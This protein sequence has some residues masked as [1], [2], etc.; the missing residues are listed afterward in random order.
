M[1]CVFTTQEW[2]TGASFLPISAQLTNISYNQA[3][4][5]YIQPSQWSCDRPRGI[6]IQPLPYWPPHTIHVTRERSR[7][8]RPQCHVTHTE[9]WRQN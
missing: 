1:V 5:F 8:L 4:V 2:H 9:H 7:S 6:L 3:R